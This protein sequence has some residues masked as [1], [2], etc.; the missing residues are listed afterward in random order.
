MAKK[1]ILRIIHGEFIATNSPQLGDGICLGHS[2]WCS[3]LTSRRLGWEPCGVPGIEPSQPH[4]KQVP[5]PLYNLSGPSNS[6]TYRNKW[7]RPISRHKLNGFLSS[8]FDTEGCDIKSHCWTLSQ[9]IIKILKNKRKMVQ[10]IA[11]WVGCA[12]R[13]WPTYVL[14]PASLIFPWA[15]QKIGLINKLV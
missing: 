2:Q 15:C 14:S 9:W 11:Q 8:R 13:T 1:H 3:V 6:F 12:P 4:A 5:Y 10:A 7:K